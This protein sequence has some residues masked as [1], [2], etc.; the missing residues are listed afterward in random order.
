MPEIGQSVSHY[1]ILERIGKMSCILTGG[2]RVLPRWL[3]P[4]WGSWTKSAW[5]HYM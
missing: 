5:R 4:I 3:L 2:S 1:R